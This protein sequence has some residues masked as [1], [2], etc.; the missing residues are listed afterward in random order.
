LTLKDYIDGAVPAN[1][2][3]DL[4]SIMYVQYYC[5]QDDT[6]RKK[7]EAL[8][9]VCIGIFIC[10]LFLLCLYYQ[11]HSS[12]LEYKLWDVSTVT[13]ADFTAETLISERMW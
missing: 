6:L 2:C 4:N 9:I 13:A 8:G 12:R 10:C 1:E 11:Q 7:Q 3:T 5:K